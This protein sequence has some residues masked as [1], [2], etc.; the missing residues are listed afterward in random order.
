M[1]FE[2]LVAKLYR[3]ADAS[4]VEG[5]PADGEWK[6]EIVRRFKKALATLRRDHFESSGHEYP[7]S[8][9]GG[10]CIVCEIIRE[11]EGSPTK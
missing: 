8:S 11:I 6:R 2:E 9:H 5:Y 7:E 1:K 3:S 4:D 10:Y